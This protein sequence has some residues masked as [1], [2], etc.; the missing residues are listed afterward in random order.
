MHILFTITSYPP[1]VGGTQSYAHQLAS[2]FVREGHRVHVATFWDETR[3][4]WLLGTTLTA[5]RQAREYTV[6]GVQVNRLALTALDRLWLLPFVPGY[7]AIQGLALGQISRVVLRKLRAIRGDWQIVHNVRQG[8]EGLSYA[9]LKLARELGVP[10]VLTPAHHPRWGGWLHR[11]YHALYREADAVIALTQAEKEALIGLGVQGDRIHVTGMGPVLAPAPE[12]ERFRQRYK[13]GSGPVV[14]FLG[15]HFP[16]KGLEALL[17]A[18]GEVW[19]RFPAAQFVFVGPP[20]TYSRRLFAQHIDPRLK[21]LGAVDLETKTD[22]LAACDLL[23][24]PS[25]QESFG[26]VYTEAWM[27]GKPVIGG[28]IPALREV[29][30]D[31]EDGYL[32]SQDPAAVGARICSLLGDPALRQRMGEQ[33]RD[34]VLRSYTWDR[35]AQHTLDVYRAASGLGPRPSPIGGQQ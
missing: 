29:I 19:Q 15:T 33:G 12:G 30:S 14:L 31:G 18:T 34:K 25:T 20:T 24:V 11:Y 35:L 27:L 2:S 22:A 3:R 23:C 1:S 21:E 10:F 28:D 4:D 26:G 7:W 32:V 8:R 17:L 16:Y 6:D 5:H 13:L 9:S